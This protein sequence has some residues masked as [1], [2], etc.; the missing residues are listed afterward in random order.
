MFYMVI[1]LVVALIIAA[2]FMNAVQ[3]HKERVEAEKR[4]ELA[5]LKS[6]VDETEDVL[7]ASS[8]FPISQQLIY[9]MHQRIFGALKVMLELNPK[10]PDIKQRVKEADDRSKTIDVTKSPP[11]D[12]AFNLPNNEKQIIVYIQGIKKLRSLLRSENSK[13]KI[14][15][16]TFLVEDKRLDKLQLKVNVETL[17]KRATQASQSNMIGSARQYLEKAMGA[18]EG[19]AEPDEYVARKKQQVSQQLQ[20]ISDNLRNVNASDRQKKTDEEKNELDELFAPKKKW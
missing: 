9:I 1:G 17:V 5:K 18:L 2:I 19:Q 7:V 3:Q 15:T 4:T 12:E 8:Q 10:M 6:I 14:D 16:Q 13:G 11:P 20:E